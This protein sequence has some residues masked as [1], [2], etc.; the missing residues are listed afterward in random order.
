[1]SIMSSSTW[2]FLDMYIFIYIHAVYICLPAYPYIKP[3][4]ISIMSST[5][6]IFLAIS[7]PGYT[8]IPIQTIESTIDGHVTNVTRLKKNMCNILNGAFMLILQ[9][10]MAI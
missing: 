8:D 1:M 10:Y 4:T 6:L 7:I 5:C 9:V 3:I 2:H